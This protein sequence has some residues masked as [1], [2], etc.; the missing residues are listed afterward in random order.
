MNPDVT[1]GGDFT[2]SADTN[3]ECV[4]ESPADDDTSYVESSTSGHTDLYNYTTPSVSYGIVGCQVNTVCRETDGTP[5][6]LKTVCSSNGT[7]SEDA[8]QAI[9]TTDYV[10]L[11]RIVEVDPDTT[12]AWTFEGL[13]AA[14]FGIK[15]V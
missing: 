4:D 3:Y 14:L 1:V 11:N 2:P 9:G 8:G 13:N 15:V 6:S 5:F 10:S 7:A 12:T